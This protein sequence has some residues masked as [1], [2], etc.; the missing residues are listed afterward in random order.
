[1]TVHNRAQPSVVLLLSVKYPHFLPPPKH[2]TCP[3]STTERRTDK[4]E[5][6]VEEEEK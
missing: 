6:E 5:E 1:V 2:S 4:G 3:C